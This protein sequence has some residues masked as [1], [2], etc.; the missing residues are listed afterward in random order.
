MNFLKGKPGGLIVFA[1]IAALVGGGL[2]WV[3][4]AALRLEGEQ[5]EARAQADLNQKVRVAMWRLDSRLFPILAREASRPYGHYSATFTPP[6]A[7]QRKG[8]QWLPAKVAEPSPL[9]SEVLPDWIRLHFQVSKEAGWTSPQVLGAKTANVL[10]ESDANLDNCTPEREQLLA[11]LRR[12][13][14]PET[15][16]V[17]LSE[18]DRQLWAGSAVGF[19]NTVVLGN[20]GV[21]NTFNTTPMQ[22]Q[23]AQPTQVP[24]LVNPFPSQQPG[25]G[26]TAQGFDNEVQNRASQRVQ[27]ETQ[28]KNY[29]Q[30]GESKKDS[31]K[32]SNRDV[33]VTV[34]IGPLTP[35]WLR[36][37]GN[38]EIL[39]LARLVESEGRRL[40]QGLVLDWKGV[41]Q[42]LVAEVRD[43]FPLASII[44]VGET[45]AAERVMT[46]LPLELVPGE[47]AVEI[48][49]PGWTPLRA[50]LALA[51]LAALVALGAVG[52]GGWTLLELSERRMR[53][54]SAVTH[55]LRTPLTTLRLY[56][57]MLT[58]GMVKDEQAKTEYLHTLNAESDRLNRLVGNVLDFSRLENQRP[59][60][61]KTH[62]RVSEL[63]DSVRTDWQER[64]NETGKELVV[65][66]RLGEDFK[67]LTD[68]RL[69]RQILG[70]LVDNAC[71]YTRDAADKRLWLRAS[72]QKGRLILEVEDL[73]P[74]VPAS[75]RRSIFR[76]FRR[77]RGVDATAGGVGL[78]LALAERWA[79]LL[80]GRL[81]LRPVNGEAGACFRL[82]LPFA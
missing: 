6:L 22:Q 15:F 64:C 30:E 55:E 69:V 11:R 47:P 41:E 75:E 33:P 70:T 14:P 7:W 62:A 9:L 36:P 68:A 34:R 39:V 63:L 59:R 77:G 79:R 35:L 23:S 2:A 57:D 32:D 37:E 8:D 43:L 81:S 19:E 65:E 5:L 82:E 12:Q 52:L 46:A 42:E 53:F 29:Q 3:T 1:L 71:K 40:S 78:G 44:P 31:K 74:G 13:L 27:L 18:Q 48:A 28:A 72:R 26:Q 50:G 25:K 38:E 24:G 45:S 76:P 66:N 21:G 73:G 60:L 61:E 54:V 51:W 10:N 56:L 20:E 17:Q 58:G 67:L 49:S 4:A 80:G 16:L